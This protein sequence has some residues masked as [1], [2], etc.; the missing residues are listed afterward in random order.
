MA[1][2]PVKCAE[3][4]KLFQ[5]DAI[6]D[7]SECPFCGA[8]SETAEISHL[9][10]LCS[11]CQH[12]LMVH[13]IQNFVKC[14]YCGKINRTS[15]LR[16]LEK[17]PIIP[18][19]E[20]ADEKPTVLFPILK[21]EDAP[22]P[23]LLS[24]DEE[25]TAPLTGEQQ[26]D[27]SDAAEQPV[28]PLP[29]RIVRES[30]TNSNRFGEPLSGLSSLMSTVHLDEYPMVQEEQKASQENR[31]FF[32]PT[33]SSIPQEITL[34][35]TGSLPLPDGDTFTSLFYTANPPEPSAP[36]SPEQQLGV[37]SSFPD[38][39]FAE[40]ATLEDFTVMCREEDDPP[41]EIIKAFSQQG[42]LLNPDT[43]LFENDGQSYLWF[44]FPKMLREN[45]SPENLSELEDRMLSAKKERSGKYYLNNGDLTTDEPEPSV[46][47]DALWDDLC[48]DE[49]FFSELMRFLQVYQDWYNEEQPSDYLY[50]LTVSHT[51]DLPL[52]A[53]E[54][55]YDEFP[56]SLEDFPEDSIIS[57]TISGTVGTVTRDMFT[58]P[59]NISTV[60][61]EEGIEQI[62]EGA[63][64]S[65]PS[66]NFVELPEGL[67]TIGKKAFCGCS[68]LID[69]NFPATLC[70]IGKAAFSGCSSLSTLIL[71][72]GVRLA[73]A[74]FKG[75]TGLHH[76]LSKPG[77]DTDLYY[78]DLTVHPGREKNLAH[79]INLAKMECSLPELLEKKEVDDE[80]V[81]HLTPEESGDYPVIGESCFSGCDSLEIVFIPNGTFN[82]QAYAF[83]SCTSLQKVFLPNSLADI[84]DTAFLWCPQAE[85]LFLLDNEYTHD[86]QTDENSWWYAAV[87]ALEKKARASFKCRC[88]NEMKLSLTSV[89]IPEG[90][91]AV[92]VRAFENCL[93]LRNV[94]LPETLKKIGSR[95]FAGCR[96]LTYIRF[97]ESVTDIAPDAFEDCPSSLWIP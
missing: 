17:E 31:D 56:I 36:F 59:E 1:K 50:H 68:S 54:G 21:Q 19:K 34:Q 82:I 67:T 95:A 9:S 30:P 47:I 92:P 65:F 24:T 13:T 28:S 90:I 66:L 33:T 5:T 88:E 91:E 89:R 51:S 93:E 39:P 49:V 75:C 14:S 32:S 45:L 87:D 70:E 3:C 11:E 38:D 48:G 8:I 81:E 6:Q 64:A 46:S 12:V 15:K 78:N 61:L 41:V 7:Y 4:H 83:E 73:S 25:K 44:E 58:S 69:I 29:D 77:L 42:F 10:A 43:Y 85:P 72:S 60:I 52:Y 79:I 20:P 35:D 74:A 71:P 23:D 62:G 16:F 86:D 97:P 18:D 37:T 22:L 2:I 76:L 57:V 84:Q 53:R 27:P 55:Y 96:N 26:N 94:Y 80:P 40:A 63:F